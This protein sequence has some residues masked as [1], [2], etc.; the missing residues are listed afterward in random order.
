VQGK[1]GTIMGREGV[2]LKAASYSG[3]G[4][5]LTEGTLTLD[6]QSGLRNTGHMAGTVANVLVAGDFSNAGKLEA[7]EFNLRSQ[8]VVNESS[9]EILA[10]KGRITADTVSNQGLVDVGQLRVDAN[11]TVNSGR[12]YGNEVS[13]GGG[14]LR[15]E[16]GG[17]IAAR[18]QL[19]LGVAQI[20]NEE[21]SEITSAGSMRIGGALDAD[22][23]P[24]AEPRVSPTAAA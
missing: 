15:N 20:Q 12:I 16:Q 18:V 4:A 10:N 8:S 7:D 3:D 17:V 9:G 23:Q 21:G 19:D 1:D 14:S 11:E 13:L 24:W 6:L 22:G 5:L 2:T